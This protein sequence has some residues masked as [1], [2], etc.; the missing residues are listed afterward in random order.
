[1]FH[2]FH[3]SWQPIPE[4]IEKQTLESLGKPST[5]VSLMS[6]QQACRNEQNLHGE[7]K[8]KE[9]TKTNLQ[10]ENQNKTQLQIQK[11]LP[12]IEYE[13]GMAIPGVVH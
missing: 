11:E 10:S 4:I 2:F 7:W 3:S 6:Q 12:E 5:G 8:R 1:M 9:I 13:E